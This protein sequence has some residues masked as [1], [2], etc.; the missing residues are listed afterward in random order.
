MKKDRNDDK[1][2]LNYYVL[3]FT[4]NFNIMRTLRFRTKLVKMFRAASITVETELEMQK[5]CF[6]SPT[7]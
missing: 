1:T 7:S 4:E 3:H 2:F 5:E 6:T